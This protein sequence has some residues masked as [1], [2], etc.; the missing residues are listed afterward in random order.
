MSLARDAS[1]TVGLLG[2][3]EGGEAVEAPKTNFREFVD[4]VDSRVS[5]KTV[6]RRLQAPPSSNIGPFVPPS[7]V[8]G[9][10]K[11]SPEYAGNFANR[12]PRTVG[13]D[14]LRLLAAQ[15]ARAKTCPV[16]FSCGFRCAVDRSLSDRGNLYR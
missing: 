9:C 4:F 7:A 11:D 12:C 10:A 13:P 5:L 2:G 8:L 3:K 16:A 6:Y 15:R 1:E 14:T